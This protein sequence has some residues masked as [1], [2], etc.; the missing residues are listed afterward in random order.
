MGWVQPPRNGY[1]VLLSDAWEAVRIEDIRL[2][3]RSIKPDLSMGSAPFGEPGIRS[4]TMNG[5]TIYYFNFEQRPDREAALKLAEEAI[6]WHRENLW[7]L[8][9]AVT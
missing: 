9:G 4:S 3:G 2:F 6:E 8:E 5:H 1:S 7:T